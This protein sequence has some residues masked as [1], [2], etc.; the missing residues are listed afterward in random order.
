VREVL[1][2]AGAGGA[3]LT[4]DGTSTHIPAVDRTV[5]VDTTAAGDS[6]AAG[7]LAAQLTDR[8]PADAAT[9]ACHVAATVIGHPGAITPRETHLLNHGSRAGRAEP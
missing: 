5:V 2:K 1:V 9:L 7:Y 3:W 8:T 6:F 4:A